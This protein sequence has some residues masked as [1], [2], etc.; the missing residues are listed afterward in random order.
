MGCLFCGNLE[1]DY[2][3]D[4]GN[5]FICSKCVQILLSAGSE[6]LMQA[7]ELSIEKGCTNKAGA[8]E[9]FLMPREAKRDRK[10]K[11]SK[12][13]MVRKRPVRTLRPA[14]WQIRG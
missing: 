3:P 12:R 7:H 1:K 10:A 11:N 2:K 5:D 6:G 4:P 8:I 9:S 13:N 14:R